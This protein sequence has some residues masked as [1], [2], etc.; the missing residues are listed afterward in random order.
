MKKLSREEIKK[1]F[2]KVKHLRLAS[3]FNDVNF[4]EI[5]YYS[6]IDETNKRFLM[7]REYKGDMMGIVW[8]IY[9]AKEAAMKLGRCEICLKHRK[10]HEVI[11]VYTKTK[12]LPKGIEYR[13][14]GNFVCSDYR[15]CNQD[16]KNEDG[17]EKL[18]DLILQ[19]EKNI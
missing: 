18:F 6:W 17:I 8:K 9:R 12:H 13:S 16:M 7:L 3:D 19:D 15:K 11:F 10:N 14:R 5:K 1:I 2:K 4:D